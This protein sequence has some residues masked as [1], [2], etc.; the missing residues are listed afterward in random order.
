[1]EVGSGHATEDNAHC[2]IGEGEDVENFGEGADGVEIG[3]FWFFDE[4]VF[5]ADDDDFSVLIKGDLEGTNGHITS[6]EQGLNHSGEVDS[7]SYG[8]Y[9][10][11]GADILGIINSGRFRHRVTLPQDLRKCTS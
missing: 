5:L 4:L 3:A 10:E 11:F 1:V 7:I 2:S 9:R 6:D 8:E